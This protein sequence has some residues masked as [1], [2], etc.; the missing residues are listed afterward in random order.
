MLIIHDKKRRQKSTLNRVCKRASV[1]T[2]CALMNMYLSA[3]CKS[4]FNSK[5]HLL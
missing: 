1:A 4:L 3:R 5:L 2:A